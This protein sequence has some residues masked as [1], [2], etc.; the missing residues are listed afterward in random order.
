MS[1][2]PLTPTDAAA[3]RELRLRALREHP[4]AFTSSFEEDVLQPVSAT[5]RRL[6]GTG[7][8][9]FLGAFAGGALQGM[10]GLT[11]ESR[12]KIRHKGHIVS[13]Y[14]A[15]ESRRHGL[16]H[17]LLQAAIDHARAGGALAQLVL[18]V[19]AGNDAARR[20]YYDAG[21]RTFGVEPR[22]IKVAGAYHDKEHMILFL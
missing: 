5:E 1:I 4:E 16:G 21:F 17:A 8:D 11:V 9:R 19:T 12:A 22:A 3:F 14:V 6:A 18:T 10:V 13:M 2:R 20:L 15:P 7:G